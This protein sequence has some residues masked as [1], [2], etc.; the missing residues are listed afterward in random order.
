[1]VVANSLFVRYN[2]YI[3]LGDGM[4]E[5]HKRLIMQKFPWYD[6]G[7]FLGLMNLW[8]SESARLHETQGHCVGSPKTA[9][10]LKLVAHLCERI[11]KD[12]YSNPFW[13]GEVKIDT[14]LDVTRPSQKLRFSY[15]PSKKVF[16]LCQSKQQRQRKADIEMLTRLINKNLLGWWD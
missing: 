8:A 9:R 15:R 4:K 14:D 6:Y 10:Q 7:Y 2:I 16:K 12:D 13:F 11:V 3:E 5:K 1:M